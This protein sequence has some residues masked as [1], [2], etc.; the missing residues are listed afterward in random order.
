MQILHFNWLRYY[1][2][3]T[4]SH[5]VAKFAGFENIPKHWPP[6]RVLW[7]ATVFQLSWLLCFHRKQQLHAMNDELKGF[8]KLLK[9]WPNYQSP[10]WSSSLELSL[11]FRTVLWVTF[12]FW[13]CFFMNSG[14]GWIFANFAS[15][16][17]NEFSQAMLSKSWQLCNFMQFWRNRAW[18]F[19]FVL[20]VNKYFFNLH[21]LT[22]ETLPFLSN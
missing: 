14:F 10:T 13:R 1:R 11:Q 22:F 12:P 4:N 20:F 7:N 15:E 17:M 5:R 8:N 16:W 2:T 18:R 9:T 19:S 21:L 3:I 6:L